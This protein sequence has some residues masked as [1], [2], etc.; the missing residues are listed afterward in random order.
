MIEKTSL[1]K[2]SRELDIRPLIAFFVTLLAAC[3][4]FV[5]VGVTPFGT[6]NIMTSDLA[7]Q[8]GPY[9]VGLR[10][11]LKR[12]ESL[13][14]S[15]TQGM[16]QNSMGIFAY[17]LSSPLN[18]IV[19]LFPKNYLQEAIT[20]M[21][22]VKMAFAGSFMTWLLG[23][24]FN[25]KSKLTIIF[26]LMYPFCAF[27]LAF[28]FNIMWLDGIAIL[29]LLILFVDEF[30][31]NRRKWPKVT[32]IL[33]LL[34]VSGYYMAYMVGIF[35][36]L[37]LVCVMG[38][39]GRFSGEKAKENGK[40][41]GWYILSAAVAAMVS[42]V[43]LLPAGIDTIRNGDYTKS[44]S[45]TLDPEF[46]LRKL[47]DQF[48]A[49]GVP[50]LA[51]NLPYFFCGLTVLFLCLLLFFNPTISK[52]LKKA[53][54]AVSGAFLLSFMVPLLNRAWHLFDDPNWFQFRNAYLLS[55]VMIL[56][57]FYSFLHMQ[58]A[59]KDAFLRAYGVIVGLC[60]ISQC[61]GE[62]TKKGN[63][64]FATLLFLTLEAVLLYGL[65]LE[66]W[67]EQI[68]NLRRY[69][70][71]FLVAVL[72]IE[73]AIF[74]SQRYI[75]N[76]IGEANDADKFPAMLDHMDTLAENIDRSTWSR[77]EIEHSWHGF[78]TANTLPDY[79]D[80]KS[81]SSFASMA[82]KKTNHF[83]KQFGYMTNYNYFFVNHVNIIDPVDALLGV[84]YIISGKD[85]LSELNFIAKED[86]SYF[87]YENPYALPIAYLVEPS[88]GDFDGYAL[89]KDL[90]E[91]N[92][93]D[94]QEDWIQSLTGLDASGLYDTF[95]AEWEI[96]NG[97]RTD[98]P[99]FEDTKIIREKENELNQE[100]YP[101]KPDNM[102][103]FYRNNDIT[104]LTLRTK[105]TITE[106][107]PLY[108]LVPFA[109][110]QCD[111]EIYVDNKLVAEQSSSDYSQILALGTYS[112][113][114]TITIDMRVESKAMACYEPIF[115]Y[116]HIDEFAPHYE[117]LAPTTK[118][119]VVED[120][121]VTFTTSSDEDKLLLT[122]IPFEDGWEL[123]VDGQKVEQIAYQDA[124]ISI[125]LSS[126]TH[127]IELRFTPPGFKAGIVAT[128]VGV[129]LFVALSIIVTRK[130]KNTVETISVEAETAAEQTTITTCEEEKS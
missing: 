83:M 65:T 88:A 10:N 63:V 18:L 71:G 81:I 118:D 73:V 89:E 72:F 52:K 93:F 11:A 104:T 124:F 4:M 90:K 109:Q 21:I 6:K 95:G 120:G 125:P 67:P 69:G 16:G 39:Q 76:I 110:L 49:N 113:G 85:T 25:T 54:A 9:L 92:Y 14:Y 130:K 112:V 116:C 46:N 37:Y 79:I 2:K 103:Y 77:T 114:Q 24:K 13:L 66:K 8:Y 91:K 102:T 99:P 38:Y 27:V 97:E 87:L 20:V 15:Q 78:I 33:I 60:V 47:V 122:T 19:L 64:F 55:F 42:A 40:T 43:I 108:F 51:N 45:M 36:F 70:A 17:Y 30:I 111:S 56:V 100:P 48:M 119:F 58:D 61:C 106:E 96:I 86:D 128:A 53:I 22:C 123:W 115:A 126:G 98:V 12:G 59:G 82:N 94:F 84:R 28:I 129:V 23:R 26:G 121:H 35:S 32:L 117:K 44:P 29:P 34:F 68:S 74:N 75:P 105:L 41:V 57:A 5:N 31:E 80:T 50:D 101:Y 127:S 7:A 3:L 107:A 1:E 62:M